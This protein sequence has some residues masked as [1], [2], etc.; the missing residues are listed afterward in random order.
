MRSQL[1]ENLALQVAQANKLL[2][3][4]AQHKN[5]RRNY[6]HATFISVNLSTKSTIRI[7]GFF[8]HTFNVIK[9]LLFYNSVRV[10]LHVKQLHAV[11]R[12]IVRIHFVG[13]LHVICL[14]H[15]C[16]LLTRYRFLLI[17]FPILKKSQPISVFIHSYTFTYDKNK[18]IICSGSCLTILLTFVT[19]VKW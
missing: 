8:L 12:E 13:S 14:Y 2:S 11:T 4:P 3:I 10:N 9:K 1:L 15:T 19:L 7:N 16:K 5:I 18:S 6:C 17:K